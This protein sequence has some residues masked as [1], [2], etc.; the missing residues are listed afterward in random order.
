MLGYNLRKKGHDELLTADYPK[1]QEIINDAIVHVNNAI[2]S[3]NMATN[4]IGP[5]LADT[6]HSW[7]NGRIIHKY[8]RLHDG[9][10]PDSDTKKVWA[11][12]IV[13]AIRDN[14]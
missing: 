1:M 6:I 3:M 2:N 7:T 10:H 5:W 14:L 4:V 8:P 11:K 9:L 13:K 12:K